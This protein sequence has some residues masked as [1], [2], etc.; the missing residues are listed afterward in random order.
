MTDARKSSAM[1]SLPDRRKA[2]NAMPSLPARPASKIKLTETM[3]VHS[4][5]IQCIRPGQIALFHREVIRSF[6]RCE[7]RIAGKSPGV[8][9]SVSNKIDKEPETA[10]IGSDDDGAGNDGTEP[11]AAVP[12]SA[13]ST[14][15]SLPGQ[16]PANG[17]GRQHMWHATDLCSACKL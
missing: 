4:N 5:H 3:T 2:G 6:R 14:E 11:A 17:R 9:S 12:H 10:E 8:A 1:P 15:P 7:V 13:S 16:P